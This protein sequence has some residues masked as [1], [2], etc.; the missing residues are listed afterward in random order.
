MADRL[1]KR[2]L[3]RLAPCPLYDQA[4]ETI[5]YAFSIVKFGP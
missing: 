3:P 4:K 2:G 1:S 5:F